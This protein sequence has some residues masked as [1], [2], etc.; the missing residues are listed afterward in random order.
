LKLIA[1]VGIVGLPNA[2]KSTLLACISEAKPKIASYPFTTLTPNLGT[3]NTSDFS[4]FTVTDIPGLIEGAHEGRGLGHTF[5]RHIERTGFL[6]FLVD[7]TANNP[8]EDYRTILRELELY[9]P[10]LLKKGRVLAFNKID[11]A[12]HDRNVLKTLAGEVDDRS[13]VISAIRGDGVQELLEYIAGRI[14]KEEE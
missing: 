14:N 3:V 5:L 4:S 8:I 13:F 1:D 10:A 12:T 11:I 6:L 9:H 2:G 7:L